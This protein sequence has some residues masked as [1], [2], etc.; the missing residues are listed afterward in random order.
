[1]KDI[2]VDVDENVTARAFDLMAWRS[3]DQALL[4][5]AYGVGIA[6]NV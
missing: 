1:M 2:G 6:T 4:V 5:D 3:A